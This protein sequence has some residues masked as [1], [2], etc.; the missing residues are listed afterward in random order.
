MKNVNQIKEIND[1]L[2]RSGLNRSEIREYVTID[3]YLYK[4]TFKPRTKKLRW[5]LEQLFLDEDSNDYEIREVYVNALH[6][7]VIEYEHV[8]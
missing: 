2:K 4:S 3:N 6:Q 8:W 5:E 1:A 7:V